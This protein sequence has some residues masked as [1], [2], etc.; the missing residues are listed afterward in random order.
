MTHLTSEQLVEAAEGVLS[1]E[2]ARHVEQCELC[3][4]NVDTLRAVLSDVG[5]TS[6]VPEPSPLFWEHFSRRVREATA[7]ERLPAPER[8]WQ[9]MWRPVIA[10]GAVAGAIGLAVLLRSGSVQPPVAVEQAQVAATAG[11]LTVSEDTVDVV[12]AVVGDLSFD[13]LRA[14]DL[15]PSRGAVDLAVSSLSAEQQRELMRLVREELI[16][17]E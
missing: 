14:A 8:W 9:G 4:T 17:S 3:R 10:L 1:A 6:S 5:D 13:E 16:G 7:A 11:E 12:T 15:V 2:R